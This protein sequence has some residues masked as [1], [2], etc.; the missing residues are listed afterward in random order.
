MS[1]TVTWKPWLGDAAKTA[2]KA[3]VANALN[4]VAA[5]AVRYVQERWPRD[6]GFSANT[7]EVIEQATSRKVS[8]KWGNVTAPYVIWIEIGARGRP[9]RHILRSS[10][11]EASGWVRN[12]MRGA[13]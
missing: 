6:T 2:V 12:R 1:V 4:D 8:V 5:D 13:L 7:M 10:L 9:G 11:Q 3:A